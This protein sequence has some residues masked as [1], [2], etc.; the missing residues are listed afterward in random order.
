LPSP[1]PL[2]RIEQLLREAGVEAEGLAVKVLEA[3]GTDELNKRQ[4]MSRT[5][6]AFREGFL[7]GKRWPKFAPYAADIWRKSDFYA[8]HFAKKSA[9]PDAEQRYARY[10]DLA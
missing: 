5:E 3:A 9:D 6:Q 10:N 2:Q 4:L 7:L 1:T 8:R